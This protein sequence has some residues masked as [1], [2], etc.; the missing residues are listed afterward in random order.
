FRYC[1]DATISRNTTKS[2][3]RLGLHDLRHLLSR[4]MPATES[5]RL[6]GC[7]NKISDGMLVGTMSSWC[8]T[9]VMGTGRNRRAANAAAR[10]LN[11]RPT[12]L[13]N[14]RGKC[15]CWSSHT[16]QAGLGSS[17]GLSTLTQ[18]ALQTLAPEQ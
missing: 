14:G 17:L 15:C 1:V 6:A 18:R 4:L 2:S 11:L 5:R 3:S 9:H 7:G 10:K 16:E 8:S 13:A 12:K